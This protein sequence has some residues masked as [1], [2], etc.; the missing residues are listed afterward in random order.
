MGLLKT[1]PGTRTTPTERRE[2]GQKKSGEP[3][4]K[5]VPQP[6]GPAQRGAANP[7]GAFDNFGEYLRRQSGG[8]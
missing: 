5:P 2:L 1:A 8:G 6:K 3:E 4:P 7:Y